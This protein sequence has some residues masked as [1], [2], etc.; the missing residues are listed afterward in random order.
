VNPRAWNGFRQAMVQIL[1]H[2]S[3]SPR[4]AT[5]QAKK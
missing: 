5:N 3:P 1:F 2:E 4:I